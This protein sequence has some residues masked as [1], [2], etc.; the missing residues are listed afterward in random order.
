MR[1]LFTHYVLI[2][3]TEKKKEKLHKNK[4]FKNMISNLFKYNL[5]KLLHIYLVC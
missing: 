4:V 1:S 5:N 2:Y 3:N